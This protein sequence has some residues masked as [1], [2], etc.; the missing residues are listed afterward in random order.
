MVADSVAQLRPL[1]PVTV[2]L[3]RAAL[4]ST[5]M[6]MSQTSTA[7]KA[8]L[9]M[10]VS[11]IAGPPV[12]VHAAKEVVLR[13]AEEGDVIMVVADEVVE[14]VTVAAVAAAV[15]ASENVSIET[16]HAAS[17]SF[18]GGL[19]PIDVPSSGLEIELTFLRVFVKTR[20]AACLPVGLECLPANTTSR[21]SPS[22]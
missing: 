22:V 5:T 19:P 1:N 13:A 7:P 12:R 20:H 15:A 14:I 3:S 9:P 2:S 8:S 11:R 4:T 16:R 10:Q 17:L 18:G 21:T 6:V